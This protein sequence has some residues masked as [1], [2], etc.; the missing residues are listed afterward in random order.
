MME[1]V[2]IACHIAGVETG[3]SSPS[4]STSSA[5]SSVFTPPLPKRQRKSRSEEE[6]TARKTPLPP[7]KQDPVVLPGQK[8]S[9][10]ILVALRNAVNF[11]ASGQPLPPEPKRG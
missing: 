7:L 9:V 4:S 5:S 2:A 6:K 11:F 10:Q 3:R 8:L 1:A